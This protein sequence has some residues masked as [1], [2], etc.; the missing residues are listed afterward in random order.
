MDRQAELVELLRQV[1]REQ[2]ELAQGGF[3]LHIH[4]HVIVGSDI[5]AV[6]AIKLLLRAHD[7]AK[8]EPAAP[9]AKFV[10]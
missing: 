6:T 1:V 8:D 10:T 9:K 7:A 5:G 2:P 3:H 4:G